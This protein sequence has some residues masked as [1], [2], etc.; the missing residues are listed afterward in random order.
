MK[1]KSACREG[2]RKNKKKPRPV[3]RPH[4]A[5]SRVSVE[6]NKL[7]KIIIKYFHG[8]SPFWYV[9]LVMN[10]RIVQ[11]VS[12]LRLKYVPAVTSRYNNIGYISHTWV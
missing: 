5:L 6:L 10:W 7:Q 8:M 3:N 2:K 9:C 12:C 1:H 4:G 11:G